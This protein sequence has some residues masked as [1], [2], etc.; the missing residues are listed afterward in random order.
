MDDGIQE[1]EK[2]EIAKKL[3]EVLSEDS[4]EQDYSYA[5]SKKLT[6]EILEK[7]KRPFLSTF[8][9]TATK[10]VFEILK[11]NKEQREFL[12]LPPSTWHL[13]TVFKRLQ[14]FALS[15]LIVNDSAERNVKLIQ[16]FIN[17]SHDES[18]RQDLLLAL[19]TERKADAV[20]KIL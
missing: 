1:D 4:E 20:K 11:M 2:A 7:E 10:T 9:G 13:L 6:F 5:R 16:D 17:S 14:Q 19:E 15:L 8:V 3:Y 18:L 12:L